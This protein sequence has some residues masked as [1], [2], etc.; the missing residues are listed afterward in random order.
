MKIIKSSVY[1]LSLQLQAAQQS[2]YS[3]K[4]G[5]SARSSLDGAGE[6]VFSDTEICELASSWLLTDYN[7]SCIT[8]PMYV[9]QAGSVWWGHWIAVI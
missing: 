8:P 9:F 3:K 1:L 4:D 7:F 6:K 5:L 2:G